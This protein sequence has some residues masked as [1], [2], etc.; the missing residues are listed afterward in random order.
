MNRTVMGN[1]L[2]FKGS[3]HPEFGERDLIL[4]RTHVLRKASQGITAK[5]V[6]KNISS[7]SYEISGK[8][9][10]FPLRK[11]HVPDITHIPK[12]TTKRHL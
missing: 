10:D 3:P 6:P 11:Y 5:F 7:T 12:E 2:I 8:D 1:M 4:V 9:D